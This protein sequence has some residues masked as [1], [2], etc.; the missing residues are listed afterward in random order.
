[1]KGT[2]MRDDPPSSTSDNGE[3]QS[4]D[5]MRSPKNKTVN[6]ED[7]AEGLERAV[8]DGNEISGAGNTSSQGEGT[9]HSRGEKPGQELEARIVKLERL[10]AGLKAKTLGNRFGS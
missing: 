3:L 2:Q 8:E 7:A 5:L 6:G 10:I 4:K 9:V 1:M